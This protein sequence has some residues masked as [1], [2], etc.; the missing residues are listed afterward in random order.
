MLVSQTRAEDPI[1]AV[2]TNECPTLF[3]TWGRSE[4]SAR[5]KRPGL[6]L[7]RG[8]NLQE[9]Y[10]GFLIWVGLN[11]QKGRGGCCCCCCG[12]GGD[13]SRGRGRGCELI[14]K[15]RRGRGEI[16]TTTTTTTATTTTTTTTTTT[17]AAAAERRDDV[18]VIPYCRWSSA[19]E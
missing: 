3:L 13:G 14:V 7:R 10:S 5:L 17:A 6:R 8:W 18:D 4:H 15:Q 11:R 19:D 9:E 12:G 2:R 16:R 1:T